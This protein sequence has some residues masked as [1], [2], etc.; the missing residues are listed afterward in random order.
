MSAT[1]T[2][3]RH[4]TSWMQVSTW[5]TLHPLDQQRFH[6]ALAACFDELGPGIDYDQFETAMLELLTELHPTSQPVDR[7]ERIRLWA[8]RA[9]AIGCYLIDNDRRS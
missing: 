4:L 7:S 1:E 9:E 3:K 8:M 5:D 2:L 6:R